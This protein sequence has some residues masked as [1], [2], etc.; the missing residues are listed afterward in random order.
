MPQEKLIRNNKY[1]STYAYET[2][3]FRLELSLSQNFAGFEC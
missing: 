1:V 2:H 3:Y